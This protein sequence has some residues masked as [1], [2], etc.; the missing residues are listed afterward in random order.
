MPDGLGER[1]RL[2]AAEAA[3]RDPRELRLAGEPR[4]QVGQLGAAVGVGL[5]D[6]AEHELARGLEIAQQVREQQR[7]RGVGPVQVVEHEDD[8]CLAGGVGEQPRH[9]REEPVAPRLD[10][11]AQRARGDDAG[12][13]AAQRGDEARELGQL[14]LDRARERERLALRDVVLER[15]DER[16]VGHERLDVATPVEHRRALGVRL[17][18]ELGRQPGL[19]DAGLADQQRDLAPAVGRLLEAVAQRLQGRLATD[20]R[21]QLRGERAGQRD[22]AG[23]GE[24]R[25]RE[26]PAGRLFAHREALDPA[27]Q[28]RPVDGLQRGAGQVSGGG[29]AVVR[30]LGQ[31]GGDHDVQRL[32]RLG[33]ERGDRRRRRLEMREQLGRERVARVRDAAGEGL[34][35]DAAER[36][37]VGAGVDRLLVDLLG[38]GVVEG[39][40]ERARLGELGV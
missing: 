33:H 21:A 22:P 35:E 20:E 36:V 23:A 8:R 18:G 28:G 16:L 2:A 19:A 15:A 27:R 9:R 38:R 3:Q 10:R 14:R 5:A 12:P 1:V 39:A 11:L 13:G 24:R 26:A 40:H 7:G 30:A 31:R 37:D 34:E 29:V 25:V 32:R 6:R 4:Q 17:A